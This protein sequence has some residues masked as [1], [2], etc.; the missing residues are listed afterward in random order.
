MRMVIAVAATAAPA[1]ASSVSDESSEHSEAFGTMA[2]HAS[3]SDASA[4]EV[5]SNLQPNTAAAGNCH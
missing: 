3:S 2:I 5:A 4:T 1:T